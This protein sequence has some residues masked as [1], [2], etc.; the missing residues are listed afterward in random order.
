MPTLEGYRSH[1]DESITPLLREK[2][3]ARVIADPSHS[4]G[5]AA[6]VESCALA[7]IA[8]GADGLCIEAHVSP[9]KGI[10]DDPKQAVTPEVLGRIIR[11][12]SK[13]WEIHHIA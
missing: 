9:Q 1:P 13:L 6:Y 7:A 2:T 5:K 8:Y 11:R 12:A 10:G 3:W 4:V